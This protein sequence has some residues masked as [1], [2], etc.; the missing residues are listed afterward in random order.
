MPSIAWQNGEDIKP[1][2]GLG[3]CFSP[4]T[5]EKNKQNQKTN[6]VPHFS[7]LKVKGFLQFLPILIIMKSLIPVKKLWILILE[8]NTKPAAFNESRTFPQS[9]FYGESANTVPEHGSKQRGND[10]FL[11][12]SEAFKLTSHHPCL[13]CS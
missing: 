9:H 4:D 11:G 6:P 8:V 1:E 3:F 5:L 7:F 10:R 13:T 12:G 2:L